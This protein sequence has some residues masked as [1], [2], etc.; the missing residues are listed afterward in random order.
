LIARSEGGG[1]ES[2]HSRRDDDDD[3]DGGDGDGDTHRFPSLVRR[4]EARPVEAR[5]A[6]GPALDPHPSLARTVERAVVDD[7]EGATVGEEGERSL[8]RA[9]PNVDAGRTARD[10]RIRTRSSQGMWNTRIQ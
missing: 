6:A 5:A 9:I 3:D 10:R 8:A 1:N 2:A 4:R 7:Y